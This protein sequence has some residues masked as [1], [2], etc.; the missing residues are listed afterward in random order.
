M[1]ALTLSFAASL[2]RTCVTVH[3]LLHLTRMGNCFIKN[4][5]IIINIFCLHK[6]ALNQSWHVCVS[7]ALRIDSN[8][9]CFATLTQGHRFSFSH[10]VFVLKARFPKLPA[11][12]FI[13]HTFSCLT[14]VRKNGTAP[15]ILGAGST[16]S[17][18]K[19]WS[20][21]RAQFLCASP[22]FKQ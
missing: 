8:I 21:L 16:G 3:S 6:I 17:H 22:V 1:A 10:I 12:I 2:P 19:F 15:R 14:C 11:Q 18:R 5:L 4:E 20:C 13:F 7:W 9:R